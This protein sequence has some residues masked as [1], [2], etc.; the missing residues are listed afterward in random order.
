MTD[1]T[2]YT[3]EDIPRADKAEEP[4]PSVFDGRWEVLSAEAIAKPPRRRWLL[5]RGFD[6]NGNPAG[7]VPLGKAVALA[8][9]GGTG[10][11]IALCQLGLSVAAGVPWF[12]FNVATPGNVLLLLGEEDREE[13]QRR[14]RNAADGLG[15]NG[16]SAEQR[17][18]VLPRITAVPLAGCPVA[19]VQDDGHRNIIET[20]FLAEL[21][22]RLEEHEWSLVVVDPLSRFA[23]TEAEKDN[24]AA[25]RF[26]Q[27]VES[28]VRA[29]GNPTVVVSAHSSQQSLQQGQPGM[30]GV[31]GLVDGFRMVMTLGK[32]GAGAARGVRLH[33]EKSNYT[34]PWDDV[35][36]VWAP[37]DHG[38]ALDVASPT[39]LQAI[40]EAEKEARKASSTRGN[41]GGKPRASK[42]VVPPE[43]SEGFFPT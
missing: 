37:Q 43:S 7:A 11:T 27:A 33:H 19:F 39:A 4:A 13:V 38:A 10:K 1:P 8:A 9:G 35:T 32:V 29:P 15:G 40:E 16:L 22:Q 14:L 42:P 31:T 34:M 6:K 3:E 25:T 28:L 17:Q 26:V 36:L 18:E 41:G 30:R 20:S 2:A 23:S 21:R 24:A 12:G 5:T